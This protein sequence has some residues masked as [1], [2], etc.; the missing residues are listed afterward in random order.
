[1]HATSTTHFH[2]NRDFIKNATWLSFPYHV[3]YV[4][5]ETGI[6]EKGQM[7]VIWLFRSVFDRG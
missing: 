2:V 5:V 3:A 7:N 6:V 1:M 4:F